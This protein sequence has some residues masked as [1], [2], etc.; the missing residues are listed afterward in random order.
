LWGWASG[1]QEV[2]ASTGVTVNVDALG[3]SFT[4]YTGEVPP[5]SSN[6]YLAPDPTNASSTGQR[7]GRDTS[8]YWAQNDSPAAD[9]RTSPAPVAND[10]TYTASQAAS[11]APE[12][13]IEHIDG[14]YIIHPPGWSGPDPDLDGPGQSDG[15]IQLRVYQDSSPPNA[16][17]S[18]QPAAQAAATEH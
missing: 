3:P 7:I 6:P 15:P 18:S 1:S 5:W 10:G 4:D 11:P 2:D 9:D 8:L 16:A 17:S 14:G 12:S 13:T